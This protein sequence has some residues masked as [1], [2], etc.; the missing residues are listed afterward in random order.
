V[1]HDPV[2]GKRFGHAGIPDLVE[3][4]SR[5]TRRIVFTHFGSWFYAN[6]AESIK[7]ISSMSDGVRVS[8]ARDGMVIQL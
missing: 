8:A 2:T 1:R 7:K 4:F 3:F 5:F 6:I